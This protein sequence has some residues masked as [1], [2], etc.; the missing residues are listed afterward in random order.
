MNA[1]IVGGGLVGSLWS[2][3]LARRGI[4][5]EVYERRPD[6]RRADIPAGRS[7]NLAVSTRGLHALERVGLRDE[8]LKYGVAM[9]GRMIHAPS[10][11][12]S[13]LRYGKDDSECIYSISRG[14]LNKV[15]MTEAEKTG[16]VRFHFERRVRDVSLREDGLRFT[17]EAGEH[18]AELLFGTD[19]SA[20]AVRDAISP[21]A[22]SE[23][24]SYGYKELTIAPEHSQGLDK[25]ALHIWPRGTYML[26]AL[27]NYDDSYTCTLFLPFTHFDRLSDAAAVRAFFDRDFKD[28]V[29]RLPDLSEQ[30]FANPT[31]R[32]VTVKC[33]PWNFGGKA[34][35]LGDAAHA[36]VPFFGQGMNCGFEDCALLDDLMQ[37]GMHDLPTLFSAFSTMRKPN[38]DAI[39]DMAVENFVEMRDKVADPQFLFEREVEK[40]LARE[41]PG[42]YVPRYGLVTFSRVP[43]RI[44]YEAGVRQQAILRELCDGLA[45]PQAVD[46]VRAKALIVDKLVPLVRG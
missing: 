23:E 3:F 34:L 22:S 38:A 12:Q 8:I 16:R 19:G 43:Y 14:S 1:S 18:T 30:F 15:L 5:S 32:M 45:E 31:G 29:P 33:A 25:N 10:G 36:I 20:S 4:D 9:R 13:L 28:A 44:A 6:M 2:I 11:E 46:L 21:R 26:I 17:D 35:L 27:P 24:L 39:A 42:D 37:K 7:I 41:F 40:I